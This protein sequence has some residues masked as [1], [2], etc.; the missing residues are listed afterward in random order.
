MSILP[1][2]LNPIFNQAK[3]CLN[4]GDYHQA[5]ELLER[6]IENDSEDVNYYWYLGLVYLLQE[7]E[8][9]AQTTW[10]LIM[11][12][13]DKNEIDQWIKELITI[14]E[15]A[16]QYQE[17]I[18]NLNL[19]WLIRGHIREI[20]PSLINNLLHLIDLEIQL[21]YYVPQHL[22]DWK[23]IDYL[24]NNSIEVSDSELFLKII[25]NILEFPV[26]I[27]IDVIYACLKYITDIDTL[28]AIL[29][30]TAIKMAYD[31]YRS[32]YAVELIRICLELKPYNIELLDRLYWFA[33]MAQ[34][35]SKML[36]SA[37][38]FLNQS[39]TSDLKAFGYYKV[40]N[41]MIVNGL[42]LKAQK[43]LP[44]YIASLHKM[45]ASRPK[46][47]NPIME[48]SLYN[49]VA[50]LLYLEDNPL[51]YRQLQNKFS[52]RFQE[53]LPNWLPCFYGKAISNINFPRTLKIGYIAHTL[54]RHSVGWLSRW[55]LHY[56]NHEL[57]QT[58]L[59]LI[60][61]LE[62]DV[63]QIWFREK[64]DFVY[65]FSPTP[66]K[67]A[68]QIQQD[69][70]DILVDLDS[71]SNAVTCQIL[72][73]KAAPIQITWLG[74]DATGLPAI[75]YFIA[76][77]YSL[78][79]DA[80]EYYQE[81]IWRLP[82]A[83][84]AVNGF[85]VAVATLKRENL[86][87]NNDA[88]IY[89][90]SQVGEKRHPDIINLQMQILREVPNSYLL[91]KGRGNQTAIQQL[92]L[93]IAEKHEI[94]LNR[95]HFLEKSPSEEVHRANLSIADVILDTYPYNGATNTLEA[96][97][98]GIPLVTKVGQ[99]FVARNSYTFMINA[100]LTEGIA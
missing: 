28:I 7:K 76:D 26:S 66:Q 74:L 22:E 98:M 79:D 37:E 95:L 77:P 46:L 63:T 91:V 69:G 52:T 16:A 33:V 47:I 70:I 24:K 53:N 58:Y 5:I 21:Q 2:S 90:S 11:N 6:C 41:A 93:E 99:Q 17:E 13:G 31:H 57:F 19:S 89:L 12:Q 68:E 65:N 1:E 35:Y 94:A 87:I 100:G 48:G 62:D 54:R 42:W 75:D 20:E 10:L 27:N 97:W 44:I 45:I 56:H 80:Q 51:N 23:L 67:I 78:P 83:Y 8:E 25:P 71:V 81:T 92:F 15:K 34:D 59:Y 14:L 18:E 85:E 29:K 86:G 60:D 96:L 49:L 55:L 84:L 9:E 72:A 82:N 32:S 73:L 38:Q 64:A 36:V 88:V 40:I 39:E 50:P 4:Q 3:N 30:S 43:I 61:Q